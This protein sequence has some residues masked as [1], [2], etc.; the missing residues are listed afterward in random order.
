MSAP[1]HMSTY[2]LDLGTAS[3]AAVPR[4]RHNWGVERITIELQHEKISAPG[5]ASTIDKFRRGIH[6]EG[7]ISEQQRL[8]LLDTAEKCAVSQT[9]PRSSIVESSLAHDL[10]A[11]AG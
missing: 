11:D 5:S 3:D 8:N 1:P 7:D 4:T 2:W 6:L 9:L 10:T